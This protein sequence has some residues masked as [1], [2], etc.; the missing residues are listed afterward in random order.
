MRLIDVDELVRT[1]DEL[2]EGAGFYRP[3]YEG[4]LK[5]VKNRS[6]ID[7]V[8][9][10][11]CRECQSFQADEIAAPETGTCWNCEMVRQFDDFCSYGERKDGEG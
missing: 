9:V 4:F 1:I 2:R 5:A 8:P 3:I 7:A 10:V 11:R 6:T